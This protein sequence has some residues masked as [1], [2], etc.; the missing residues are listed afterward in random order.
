M[1]RAGPATLPPRRAIVAWD[2]SREAARATSDAIPLLRSAEL[3]LILVVDARD[4]GG[5]VLPGSELA[6]H[7]ARHGVKAEARQVPSAGTSVTRVLL[8]QARD[9][10]ADLLV[11]G[12][13]GHSR[14][15]EM[16]FGGTTRTFLDQAA[17]PVL[18]AH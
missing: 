3:V 14:V 13:Y 11:M 9:E 15:R 17:I 7:L 16:L 5:G 8:A 2:G 10:A 18:L 12:G 6:V 4:T 1:P